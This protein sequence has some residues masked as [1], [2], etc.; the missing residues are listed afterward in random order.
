MNAK[1]QPQHV[2]EATKCM[3]LISDVALLLDPEFKK[4]VEVYAKDEKTFFADF[5]KAWVKLQENGCSNLKST[6]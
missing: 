6:L 2:H 1:K 4:W 5:T 3:M